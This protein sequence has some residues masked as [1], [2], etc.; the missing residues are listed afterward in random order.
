MKKNY[1]M[2]T[3]LKILIKEIM[4]LKSTNNQTMNLIINKIHLMTKINIKQKIL[5][6]KFLNYIIFNKQKLIFKYFFN[7]LT[8]IKILKKLIIILYNIEIF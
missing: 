1:Q 5:V 3:N 7:S 8:L 2:I 4:N 6:I